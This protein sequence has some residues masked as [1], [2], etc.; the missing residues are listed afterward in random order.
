ML[1]LIEALP[2]SNK[3]IWLGPLSMDKV[4]NRTWE[5]GGMDD[6]RTALAERVGSVGMQF[7]QSLSKQYRMKRAAT[8]AQA[9]KAKLVLRLHPLKPWSKTEPKFRYDRFDTR[10][11]Q[12]LATIGELAK[13]WGDV[14]PSSDIIVLLGHEEWVDEIAYTS[15]KH[16]RL[17]RLVEDTLDSALPGHERFWYN[18][19]HR[20]RTG[21]DQIF[22]GIPA[23]IV[24]GRKFCSL[25]YTDVLRAIE[26]VTATEEGTTSLLVTKHAFDE[27][28]CYQDANKPWGRRE[29][30]PFVDERAVHYH[31]AVGAMRRYGH[32]R[33]TS[34]TRITEDYMRNLT[35]FIEGVNNG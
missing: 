33:V 16:V 27:A 2:T 32:S 26:T 13:A 30:M 12:R 29:M 31:R 8:V 17:L 28:W 10:T 6:A 24:D 19:G 18:A 9:A 11:A 7:V 3:P 15:E 20:W 25:Y 23:A 34:G 5:N 4:T 14:M 35:A 21:S 22:Q 1:K